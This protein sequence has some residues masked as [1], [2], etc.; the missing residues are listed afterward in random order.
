MSEICGQRQSV[1][2]PAKVN[3]TLG[4][5]GRRSD[6]YHELESVAAKVTFY[7]GIDI[8]EGV[9][10]PI[11]IE[12][13]DTSLPSGAQNLIWKSVQVLSGHAGR[14]LPP[15]RFHLHKMIP[16]GA[17]L[18]G[19][20]S[21][22]AAVLLALNH[23]WGLNLDLPLLMELGGRV[24]SDVPMF[25]LPGSVLMRG[26]G[27]RVESAVLAWQG[28]LVLAWPV[29]SI[30]TATVFGR[31]RAAASSRSGRAVD[32]L[33]PS[34]RTA[35]QLDEVL[36]N[37]LQ[38]CV[39]EVEPRLGEIKHLLEGL[40]HRRFHITGSGGTLFACVDVLE[41]A[42]AILRH[43]ESVAGVSARIVRVINKHEQPGRDDHGNFGSESQTG[44][45]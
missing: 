35:A 25:M 6:G 20:S 28:W 42:Q 30:S 5:L 15:V 33:D 31:W 1:I 29:F 9:E 14:A 23:R 39:L 38:A 10:S 34:C 41:E 7:D 16:V 24:G 4:V 32:C 43:I 19:G 44:Q 45:W 18:G 8:D 11:H 36:F 13:T 40:T 2:A 27:E 3:L 12:C 26:R 17:G 22:A 21:D 37:D